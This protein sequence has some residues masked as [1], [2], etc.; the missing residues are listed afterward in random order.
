MKTIFSLSVLF[1]IITPFTYIVNAQSQ[2]ALA[3]EVV[4]K[5]LSNPKLDSVLARLIVNSQKN[6]LAEQYSLNLKNDSVQ[7]IIDIKQ[8][9]PQ[10]IDAIKK[11]GAIIEISDKNLI[12][13]QVPVSMLNAIADLP[14]VN[15][16]HRPEKYRT[17]VT[18][19]GAAAINAT[20]LHNN[21][22]NGSGVKIAVLDLGFQDYQSKLQTELPS[23]V[24]VKS[25]TANRDITGGGEVHGTA[26][27][28]TVHDIAP[29]ASLYLVNFAT[30][31]EQ[32]SAVNWL[33][34]QNVDIISC[35]TGKLLG[36]KDGTDYA[37]GIVKKATDA[38][39]LWVNSAGNEA[40][41][42]W[43]GTFYDPDLNGFH[44][45][46]DG[47]ETQDIFA[48]QG[49]TIEVDLD[50]DDWPYSNQD[51]DLYLYDSQ[52]KMVGSSV[53]FQTGTQ[54]PDEEI[55]YTAAYTGYYKIKIK[56]Y[57]ATRNVKFHLYCLYCQNMQYIVPA[58]SITIPGTSADSLTV[59]ATY[60]SNDA[61]ES[62]SSQGPT[63]DGRIKPDVAAPDGASNSVYGHF[64]GTSASAPHT[65]GGAALLL[66][67]NLNLSVNQLKQA[68][69]SGAKDL[70]VPGKDNEFGAGRIDV[71]SSLNEMPQ[72]TLVVTA[73]VSSVT[74]NNVTPV[75]FTVTIKTINGTKIENAVITLK[76]QAS[77]SGITD[78]NGN[79]TISVNAASPGNVTASAARL[80][81][82]GGSINI[83]AGLPKNG[84]INGNGAVTLADAIY[85]AKHVAKTSGYET[86]F[87]D[88]DID[89]NGIVTLA[90]AIYLAK[91]ITGTSGYGTLY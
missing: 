18:S 89:G 25:F 84:D 50:W 77:G 83:S 47:D 5:K 67:M 87:A 38:G 48:T 61:L 70:G 49:S 90:D 86:L 78:A 32:N 46:A 69:E 44:N 85:L 6:I 10:Y 43:M 57:S 9:N 66:Q 60:W 13:A 17:F 45:F 21:G 81:Y 30:D 65:S 20:V 54:S 58:G 3:K 14:F 91:H 73:N 7:V 23:N 12:Q 28:E 75:R 35:S 41:E 82:T 31:L 16:I 72:Q 56:K 88:G 51:Y 68:L 62:F 8:F 33:I 4:T 19:E 39:I 15:N 36:P 42:H 79:V 71:Y 22:I 1:V 2:D 74:V 59:G 64:Y 52:L 37:D 55:V 34:S 27:A 76:G 11:A 24:V 53:N 63:D 80:G 40:E 29:G 26:V